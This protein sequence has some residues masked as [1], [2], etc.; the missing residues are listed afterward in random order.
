MEDSRCQDRMAELRDQKK[1][2]RMG[3]KGALKSRNEIGKIYRKGTFKEKIDWDE[4]LDWRTDRKEYGKLL[5]GDDGSW[6]LERVV[7]A[8]K[9]TKGSSAGYQDGEKYWS[10]WGFWRKQNVSWIDQIGLR[11]IRPQNVGEL[12]CERSLNQSTPIRT[13]DA[14]FGGSTKSQRSWRLYPKSVKRS[15]WQCSAEVWERSCWISDQQRDEDLNHQEGTVDAPEPSYDQSIPE[16]MLNGT[17][18]F[19]DV[20]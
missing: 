12:F 20:N 1:V 14:I 17:L 2:Q 15:C 7:G 10:R 9:Y 13:N 16:E 8:R 3:P 11:G 5:I 6:C 18:R 4:R 19:D